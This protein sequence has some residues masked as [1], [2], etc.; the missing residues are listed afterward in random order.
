MTMSVES[1]A[2]RMD[3]IYRR[4]R[5]VYDA[6]RRYYL[7]GRDRM[8]IDLEP[9]PC[10][11]I[12][13]I[14]CGTARNLLAAAEAYPDAELYGF[15]ISTE[16]LK[17]AR[18]AVSHS[19]FADK[20][21]LAAADATTFDTRAVFGIASPDRIFISYALSMIPSWQAVLDRALDQLPKRGE[22]HIVDFGTMQRMPALARRAMHAW[23]NKWSVTP[24]TDL[25]QI[26]RE[27]ARGRGLGVSFREG[28]LGYAAHVI[29]GSEVVN[30]R[31]TK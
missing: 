31:D 4:Q 6:T 21:H 18:R 19:P 26:I 13:E 14:G 15:D 17:S 16:M 1:A 23:L 12:L 3:A 24:R 10:G 29:A 9:P 30:D 25:E 5:Y 7:F 28:R 2:E 8:L 11:K 27:K 20:I 22:L